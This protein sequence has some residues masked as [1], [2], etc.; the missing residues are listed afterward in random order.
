MFFVLF[1]LSFIVGI[2]VVTGLAGQSNRSS[3]FWGISRCSQANYEMC[4][5][6]QVLDLFQ[7]LSTQ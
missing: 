2:T 6:Q 3:F 1:L 5:F 4:S 7:D